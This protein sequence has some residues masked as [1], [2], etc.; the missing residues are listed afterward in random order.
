[1]PA[2]PPASSPLDCPSAKLMLTSS[3][4]PVAA[5]VSSIG[6]LHRRPLNPSAHLKPKPPQ[7]IPPPLPWFGWCHTTIHTASTTL[8]RVAL[9]NSHHLHHLGLDGVTQF[10]PPPP[11]WLGWRYTIHTTSTTLAWVVLHNS[12]HL[13]HLGLGGVTQFTPPPSPWLGQSPHNSHCLGVGGVTQFTPS[14]LGQCHATIHTALAWA[15]SCHN[16]HHLGW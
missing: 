8:V 10:T 9:H 11:P 3:P 7:F 12:H 15:V 1:M 14:Q 5:E 16:S 2:T 4:L 6:K 13:H